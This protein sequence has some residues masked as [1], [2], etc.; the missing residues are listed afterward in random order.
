[1]IP[2]PQYPIF[3]LSLPNWVEIASGLYAVCCTG[4]DMFAI[5]G[6]IIVVVQ[7]LLLASQSLRNNS[8]IAQIYA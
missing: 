1:M 3:W 2:V 7:C 6:G 5:G 8:F 4:L